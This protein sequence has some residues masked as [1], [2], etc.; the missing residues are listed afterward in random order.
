MSYQVFRVHRGRTLHVIHETQTNNNRTRGVHGV[1]VLCSVYPY[2]GERDRGMPTCPKC[3]QIDNPCTLYDDERSMLAR[4]AMNQMKGMIWSGQ[5]ITSLHKKDLIDESQKLT[6][7]G[8]ILAQD[9]LQ[10]AAPAADTTGVVHARVPLASY[11][12]CDW[13]ITLNGFDK[14]TVDR[15]A[16]FRALD[17]HVTCVRCASTRIL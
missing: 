5:A 8:D 11:P 12:R 16:R 9:W 4:I 17:L 1:H 10:G 6:R 15:Y 13:S 14:M 7:R 3:L 2:S